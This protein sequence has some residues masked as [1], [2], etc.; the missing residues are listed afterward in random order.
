MV[1]RES[2]QRLFQSTRDQITARLAVEAEAPDNS[3]TPV[4]TP[5][6]TKMLVKIDGKCSWFAPSPAVTVD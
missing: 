2:V 1:T 5:D 6:W 4:V 3:V